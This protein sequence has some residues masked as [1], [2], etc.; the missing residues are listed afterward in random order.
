MT[1]MC[2]CLEKQELMPAPQNLWPKRV[3]CSSLGSCVA[4]ES[5]ADLLLWLPM[6][7]FG[8]KNKCSLSTICNKK[9]GF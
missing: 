9:K 4:C 7:M 3:L 5:N 1:K 8:M 2:K 6:L